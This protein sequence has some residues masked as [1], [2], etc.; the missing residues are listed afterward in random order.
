MARNLHRH[1]VVCSARS[2]VAT[3][4]LV[5][6]SIWLASRGPQRDQHGY[7][8]DRHTSRSSVRHPSAHSF[9][10]CSWYPASRMNEYRSSLVAP[11]GRVPVSDGFAHLPRRTTIVQQH[12]GAL[13]PPTR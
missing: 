7:A 1:C 6:S 4:V 11:V 5:S 2:P 9:V 13:I 8:S 10:V 3:K 12:S